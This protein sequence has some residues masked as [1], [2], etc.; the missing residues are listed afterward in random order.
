[1]ILQILSSFV[2]QSG[3]RVNVFKLEIL[4]IPLNTRSPNEDPLDFPVT[5]AK[6]LVKYL[7]IHI[8]KTPESLYN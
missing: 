2:H 4:N 1:M 3:F 6:T 7:G 8:G 5:I